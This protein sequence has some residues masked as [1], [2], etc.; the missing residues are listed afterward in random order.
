MNQN[1]TILQR[2]KAD[3][4]PLFKGIQI[5]ILVLFGLANYFHSLSFIPQPLMTFSGSAT[6]LFAAAICQLVVKNV[7]ALV[8]ASGDPMKMLDIFK[9]IPQQLEDMFNA[10]KGGQ[11]ISFDTQEIA[12]KITAQVTSAIALAGDTATA[13]ATAV[14]DVSLSTKD[15]VID[16]MNRK[17]AEIQADAPV[18]IPPVQKT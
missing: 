15:A 1:L 17:A 9:G 13:V 2:L 16:D 14:N 7:P 5:A 12:D 4:P 8:D 11:P 10:I 18:V 3:T 6:M